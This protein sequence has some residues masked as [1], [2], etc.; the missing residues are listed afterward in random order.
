MAQVLPHSVRSAD[1]AARQLLGGTVSIPLLNSRRPAASAIRALWRSRTASVSVEFALL[2]PPLMTLMFGFVAT[3]TVFAAL[4]AMQNNAQ[5]AA[6]LMAAGQVTSLST[7]PLSANNTTATVTCGGNLTTSQ[8]EYYACNGLPSWGTFTVTATQNCEIPS[9]SV[10]ISAS[11][12]TAAI[13]DIYQVFS[14][15]TIAATAVLMKEGQ[16][17]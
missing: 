14:G 10:S 6:R 15:K 4:S 9:V 11:G 8:V 3:N 13:G 5:Y 1:G 2:V 12:T 7:G 16:C 17:P